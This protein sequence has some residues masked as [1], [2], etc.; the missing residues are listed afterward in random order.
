MTKV[1]AVMLPEGGQSYN[2]SATEHQKTLKKIVVRE[3]EDIEKRLK[4]DINYQIQQSKYDAIKDD[5]ES[6]QE[7][8]DDSS[9]DSSKEEVP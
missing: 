5:S 8:E 2:P 3:S 7:E 4:A 9:S 6:E 1:R